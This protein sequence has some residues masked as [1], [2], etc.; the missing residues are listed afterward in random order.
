MG[1]GRTPIRRVAC[2]R[3]T[4]LVCSPLSSRLCTR[5][6]L[7]RRRLRSATQRDLL[8]PQCRPMLLKDDY[9]K[10][11]DIDIDLGLSSPDFEQSV[12]SILWVHAARTSRLNTR[13]YSTPRR[14]ET[15]ETWNRLGSGALCYIAQL[16]VTLDSWKLMLCYYVCLTTR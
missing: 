3:R 10:A 2:V 12:V 15:I 5:L 4:L 11:I 13:V 8:V 7:H 16:Y 1:Y 9:S 6:T 14:Q